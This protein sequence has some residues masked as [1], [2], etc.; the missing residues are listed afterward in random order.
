MKTTGVSD[1][2]TFGLLGFL[3]HP[4]V[5]GQLASF[6][7]ITQCSS[8]VFLFVFLLFYLFCRCLC[9]SFC[10][11]FFCPSSKYSLGGFGF[12]LSIVLHFIIFIFVFVFVNRL[13]SVWQICGLASS[14][15]F[16]QL[17]TALGPP[18]LPYYRP[19]NL[20]DEPTTSHL[21]TLN[22]CLTDH[23]PAPHVSALW[24]ELSHK[25]H[26]LITGRETIASEYIKPS[27]LTFS[28]ITLSVIG[29]TSV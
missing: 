11:L 7:L 12:V 26:L 13:L 10:E 6:D 17:L 3:G 4:T 20:R 16:T 15:W 9:V 23:Y 2:P 18:I 14:N 25:P 8:F 1:I 24:S 28:A 29:K 5:H 19:P 21:M 27:P 22:F